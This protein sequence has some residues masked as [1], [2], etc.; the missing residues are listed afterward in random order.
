MKPKTELFLYFLLWSADQL[1]RPSF[2]NLNDSFEGWSYRNGLLRQI[3]VLER[4]LFIERKFG[5]SNDRTY[6]LT[7]EGRLRALGGRDPVKQWSR[8]WDGFWRLVVFDVPTSQN[9]VRARLRRL[10]RDRGFGY[11]QNSVWLTPHPMAEEIEL[12]R[13]G[14]IDVGSLIIFEA[15]PCAGESTA[16]IVAGAWDFEFI[17]GQY[18]RH[19]DVLAKKPKVDLSRKKDAQAL[20]RWAEMERIAWNK[21][22]NC[23]PLLPQ[24]LYPREYLGHQAWKRRIAVLRAA[25]YDLK[26]F[27]A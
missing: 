26:S 15:R 24:Q 9:A 13:G 3:G 1:M 5:K 20:Q 6:R 23:D 8:A 11:L 25:R 4:Q 21:A 18:Q 19:L 14:K 27:K 2:R 17:N 22:I 16:Q 12:L 7:A 10:L